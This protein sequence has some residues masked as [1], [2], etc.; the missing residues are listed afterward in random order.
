MVPSHPR[1]VHETQL[2]VLH[3]L[4]NYGISG[5]V[6][7]WNAD[8]FTYW[9]QQVVVEGCISR[10]VP[11]RSG[12]PQGSMLGLG[13]F[14]VAG[15]HKRHYKLIKHSAVSKWQMEFY[16]SKCKTL[17]ITRWPKPLLT[18]Y[19]LYGQQKGAANSA[20]SISEQLYLQTYAGK[21]MFTMYTIKQAQPW[22][23]YRE[24]STSAIQIKTQAYRTCQTT[25]QI[26][27]HNL[28]FRHPTEY[29]ACR[30]RI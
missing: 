30:S 18:T 15:V 4:N 7:P 16:P 23:S 24:T 29:Q 14:L 13:L 8:F 22:G 10:T 21:T 5:K 6:S 1:F 20:I 27:G 28:E 2:L 26:H 9:S 11:A 3:K 19:N 17:H 12:V 25:A